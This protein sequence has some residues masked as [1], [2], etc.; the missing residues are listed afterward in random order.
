MNL[1]PCIQLAQERTVPKT[2]AFDVLTL[3]AVQNEVKR[4]WKE[5]VV[6]HLK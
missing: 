2:V 3:S 5:A 4:M 1:V 6:A